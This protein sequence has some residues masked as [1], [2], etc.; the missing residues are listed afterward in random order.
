[1]KMRIAHRSSTSTRALS[2]T[3]VIAAAVS[4]AHT[5]HSEVR[6]LPY[7]SARYEHYD[8][9]FAL[10]ND[11][12][13]PLAT[14]P[15]QGKDD[16]I[17]TYSAGLNVEATLGRQKVSL[18][19]YGSRAEYDDYEQ[20]DHD[21]YGGDLTWDW[22]IASAFDGV[23]GYT[24]AQRMVSFADALT[25]ELLVEH[26]EV[27]NGT[28]NVS[29]TPTWRLEARASKTDLESPRP[30][31]S[32]LDSTE[33]LKGL[34][35]R[36][37]GMGKLSLA[38]EGSQTDGDVSGLLL[39]PDEDYTQRTAQLSAN[40]RASPQSTFDA[41]L[42]YTERQY[43]GP[44]PDQ[45][46]ITGA[47][48]YSRTLSVKTSVSVRAERMMNSYL[49][50][51]QVLTTIDTGYGITVNWQPTQKLGLSLDVRYRESDFPDQ[52]VFGGTQD[53][54]DEYWVSALDVNFQALRWLLVHPYARYEDRKSNDPLYPFDNTVAGIEFRVGL[55]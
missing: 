6:F 20:L 42:G 12:A 5:A 43:D 16:N 37:Q 30:G 34:G 39:T 50:A 14:S 44:T 23:L 15:G 3:F 32:R 22:R 21:E 55:Q 46:A 28:F 54:K 35:L 1:M 27:L 19:G 2:A 53:R 24:R 36:Y 33:T 47:I 45:D 48:R 10:P 52:P 8:N 9:I 41:N 26:L 49:L 7:A 51:N 18:R 13:P 25:D 4:V 11:R 31:A 29:I 38:L 17:L 40:L